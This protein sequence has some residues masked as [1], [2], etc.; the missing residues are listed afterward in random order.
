[1]MSKAEKMIRKL[2]RYFNLD[3]SMK[4]KNKKACFSI[5]GIF[6]IL[7]V[8]GKAAKCVRDLLHQKNFDKIASMLVVYD[9]KNPS[10]NFIRLGRNNDGGYVLPVEALEAADVLMGYGIADDISFEREFSRR[11]NKPSFGF[12]CGVQNIETGD[13]RCCFFSECIGTSN[14]YIGGRNLPGK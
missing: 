8:G 10:L 5:V 14:I 12:D 4:K 9:V 6:L 1:M 3:H 7:F 13:N 2:G 11:F